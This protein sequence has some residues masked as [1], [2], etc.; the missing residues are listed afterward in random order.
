MVHIPFT[1]LA[2]ICSVNLIAASILT[3][4]LSESNIRLS[5]E[6][7]LIYGALPDITKAHLFRNYMD[8][9]GREVSIGPTP[10]VYAECYR[11]L[12]INAF[13]HILQY[14]TTSEVIMR[15]DLFKQSLVDVDKLNA[16]VKAENG[17][18][19]FGIT[20]FAD[21][22]PQEF[23]SQYL[24]LQMP[25]RSD[26]KRFKTESVGVVAT[27]GARTSMDWR[28]MTT[29]IKDQ[30]ACGS[31]WWVKFSFDLKRFFSLIFP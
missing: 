19:V 7:F 9:Y 20:A 2:M 24:S 5:D 14:P 29:P 18:A 13:L 8:E 15:Y 17:T 28:N 31:C 1:F 30:G 3:S 22:S 26:A 25:E 27:T 6:G 4:A 21:L 11:L 16:E 10:L 12:L 23:H